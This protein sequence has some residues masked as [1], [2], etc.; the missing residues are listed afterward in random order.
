MT[1]EAQ[2]QN[3]GSPAPAEG[4]PK[5]PDTG[6]AQG[7]TEAAG[8]AA[9]PPVDVAALHAGFT[10]KSTTVARVRDRLGLGKE[11]SDEDVLAALEKRLT[12]QSPA[13]ESSADPE[14]QKRLDGIREREWT[15]VENTYGAEMADAIRNFRDAALTTDSP[16]DMAASLYELMHREGAPPTEPQGGTESTPQ[17]GTPDGSPGGQE[18]QPA[19]RPE[20]EL[21][22]GDTGRNDLAV[23]RKPI[24]SDIT[25]GLEGSGNMREA[26][27]RLFAG[28]RR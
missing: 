11:V 22:G 9:S 25:K 1:A 21:E 3:T 16:A 24:P 5:L 27:R 8:K 18:E 7:P 14:Y 4:A 6:Q 17:E 20:D 26:A 19:P 12:P 2:A 15:F 28:S 13:S 10:R 23:S